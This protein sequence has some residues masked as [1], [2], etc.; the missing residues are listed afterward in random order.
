MS[1]LAECVLLGAGSV[2]R[3]KPKQVCRGPSRPV[4]YGQARLW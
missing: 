3:M 1:I 2:G 4:G